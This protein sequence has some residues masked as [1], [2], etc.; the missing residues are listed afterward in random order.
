MRGAGDEEE[1]VPVGERV[2]RSVV[3]LLLFGVHG[4]AD[5]VEVV[6]GRAGGDGGVGFTVVVE[7]F[8]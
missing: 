3:V 2:D 8:A 1:A 5:A 6:D 7:Q 4:G